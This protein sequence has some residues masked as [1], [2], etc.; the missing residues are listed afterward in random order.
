MR[1]AACREASIS[2]QNRS[3]ASF[4]LGQLGE[5]QKILIL[6]DDNSFS[7]RRVATEFLVNGFPQANL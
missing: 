5:D 7:N 2:G 6:T 1:S 4:R 3:N